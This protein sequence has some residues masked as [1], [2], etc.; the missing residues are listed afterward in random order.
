MTPKGLKK[1]EEELE[2]LRSVKRR[3]IAQ[4][5]HEAS[6]EGGELDDNAAY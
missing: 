3:E 4:H 2:H 5:L 6:G 1:L